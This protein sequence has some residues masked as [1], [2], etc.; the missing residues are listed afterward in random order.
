M[1]LRRIHNSINAV[2]YNIFPS[3]GNAILSGKSFQMLF[4]KYLIFGRIFHTV[5]VSIVA[6]SHCYSDK[7]NLDLRHLVRSHQLMVM[8]KIL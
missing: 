1:E 2:P 7:Y 4:Q 5:D 3:D 6:S 8:V